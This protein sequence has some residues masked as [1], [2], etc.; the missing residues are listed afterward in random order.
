MKLPV[1]AVLVSCTVRPELMRKVSL[2]PGI[3]P[4]AQVAVPSKGPDWTQSMVAAPAAKEPQKAV[5]N[6]AQTGKLRLP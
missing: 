3:A 4:F 5:I 6:A 1:E 2:R